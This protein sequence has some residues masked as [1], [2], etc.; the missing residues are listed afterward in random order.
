MR[1]S[2]LLCFLLAIGL[3][4]YV[5]WRAASKPARQ[6]AEQVQVWQTSN[7][8]AVVSARR[9]RQQTATDT[10][11]QAPAEPQ[12]V[13]ATN[14]AFI[15]G[16]QVLTVVTQIVQPQPPPDYESAQQHLREWRERNARDGID[17]DIA[18][19]EAKLRER[20]Q[21]LQIGMPAEQVVELMGKP[22]EIVVTIR[23]PGNRESKFIELADLPSYTGVAEWINLSYTPYGSTNYLRYSGGKIRFKPYDNL[24][25]N[26][27]Q[28]GK[29]NRITWGW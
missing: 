19:R 5:I 27:G 22:D 14:L 26:L 29:L 23:V 6:I 25:L 10:N 28:D 2:F 11:A 1:K 9:P 15:N 13:V 8:H 4:G 21:G 7:V 16:Q 3:I 17:Q 18:E 24:R 12:I 20:A